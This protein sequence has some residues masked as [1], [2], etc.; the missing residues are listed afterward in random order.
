MLKTAKKT[1]GERVEQR[2]L[3]IGEVA[4]AAGLGVETLRFYERRGLLGRPR[5]TESNY[6]VYDEV[7]L[8]RLAFIRRAQS[9]GFSLDEIQTIIAESEGG[10]LPCRPV[11]E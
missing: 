8:E 5:R 10:Q 11:R 3:R 6:R 7:V 9:I 1:D 2:R 4:E